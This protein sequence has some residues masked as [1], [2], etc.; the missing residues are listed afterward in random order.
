MNCCAMIDKILLKVFKTNFRRY[1]VVV[2]SRQL[3][4]AAIDITKLADRVSS[5]N[6]I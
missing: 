2:D 4:Y 1:L 3:D 5:G 6:I